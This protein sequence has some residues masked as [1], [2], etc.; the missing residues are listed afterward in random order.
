MRELLISYMIAIDN[1]RGYSREYLTSLDDD[2]LINCL[3]SIIDDVRHD[4]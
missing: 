1:Y 2:E 3:D 4:S